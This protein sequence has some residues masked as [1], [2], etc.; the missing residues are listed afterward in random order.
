MAG[1]CPDSPPA[2]LKGIHHYMKLVQKY[3]SRKE[4]RPLAYWSKHFNNLVIIFVS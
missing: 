2:T 1:K 4:F 3:D